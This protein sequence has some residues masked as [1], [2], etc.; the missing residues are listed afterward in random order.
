MANKYVWHLHEMDK[1]SLYLFIAL[2]SATSNLAY[3]TRNINVPFPPSKCFSITY[4]SINI[5]LLRQNMPRAEFFH[6][7]IYEIYNQ[8]IV[9][10]IFGVAEEFGA[11]VEDSF[12][13]G[14]CQNLWSKNISS[15]MFCINNLLPF[16]SLF[17]C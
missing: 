8:N 11:H 5:F 10:Y 12:V 6:I 14:F 2:L 13:D 1:G 4:L 15:G 9:Y 16:C 7:D 3:L 17:T